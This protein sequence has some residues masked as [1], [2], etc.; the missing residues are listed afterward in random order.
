MVKIVNQTFTGNVTPAPYL[1]NFTL[2]GN[3][4]INEGKKGDEIW[5]HTHG[6]AFNS[7][8]IVVDKATK[9]EL[10]RI[11]LISSDYDKE[12]SHDSDNPQMTS[13]GV[14]KIV[15]TSDV[16]DGTTIYTYYEGATN[17]SMSNKDYPLEFTIAE[18]KDN[19][20]TILTTPVTI[21]KKPFEPLVTGFNMA[22]TNVTYIE[23]EWDGNERTGV[24]WALGDGVPEGTLFELTVPTEHLVITD[25][26][27][28]GKVYEAT[29]QAYTTENSIVNS[30]GVYQKDPNKL[31]FEVVSIEGNKVTF[32]NL[33]ASIQSNK[34]IIDLGGD[35]WIRSLKYVYDL[36]NTTLEDVVG[37]IIKNAQGQ[38]IGNSAK[39]T[40][41]LTHIRTKKNT[42]ADIPYKGV[43]DTP[44]EETPPPPPPAPKPVHRPHKCL[45]CND[46]E[47]KEV[48][49]ST[50]KTD[51]QLQEKLRVFLDIICVIANTPCP[52]LPAMMA[53]VV[54]YIWCF[55][56]DLTNQI[57]CLR[58]RTNILKKR[59]EELCAK[60]MT[61]AKAYNLM[62]AELKKLNEANMDAYD[63]ALAKYEQ[64]K[65]NATNNS[66][67]AG[68][69]AQPI[70]KDL[71]MGSEPNA[72]MTGVGKNLSDSVYDSLPKEPNVHWVDPASLVYNN[73][74]V[75]TT[76]TKGATQHYLMRVG[77]SI[78]V[79][80]SD[81][82][83]TTYQ[84]KKVEKIVFKYRLVHLSGAKSQ[85]IF[86]AL[87]DPTVT[88]YIH[89][90]DSG[91]RTSTFKIET[92]VRVFVGGQEIIPTPENPF[93]VMFGSINS[94]N[95][96]GEYVSDFVGEFIPI[97]GS[98]ITVRNGKALNYNV[99]HIEDF[100]RKAG[101]TD[102]SWDSVT[103]KYNWVGAIAGKVT[104]PIKFSFG[105]TGSAYWFAFNTGVNANGILF[106]PVPP[107]IIKL[108][109]LNINC[110]DLTPF[111][112]GE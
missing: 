66:D 89:T 17:N 46:C 108:D 5:Y 54:Y 9:Q 82:T 23:G 73:Y 8:S 79:T 93:P 56:K 99:E 63:Q 77:D 90:W 91:G 2:E 14:Y 20:T 31:P 30:Y 24:I 106:K 102:G 74:P 83:K 65:L 6:Y 94:R 7:G 71:V 105:N 37:G 45:G 21:P 88:S 50:S 42:S 72:T 11:Y 80:Y 76:T 13:K 44:K 34:Y 70:S 25:K 85:L 112:C 38:K 4:T 68:Y 84:G 29:S 3:I 103:N 110:G 55:L 32:K 87:A 92:T 109:D 107:H 75:K 28:V 33:R 98:A 39:D 49:V 58:K 19:P 27:T 78:E 1:S 96:E 86:N 43:D 41:K 47:C 57:E 67:K 104:E 60:S 35:I 61:I 100:A 53:K 12:L 40:G 111:D 51:G 22:F 18:G 62:N 26:L 64:D 81:L 59:D 16:P 48:D 15:L 10:G 69:L 52:S 97:N 101:S 95:G 36:E